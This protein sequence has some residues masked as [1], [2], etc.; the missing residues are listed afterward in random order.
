MRKKDSASDD[1]PLDEIKRQISQ[2]RRHLLDLSKRNRLIN[3]RLSSKSVVE[4]EYPGPASIWETLVVDNKSFTF[5]WKRDL[6]PEESDVDDNG[7]LPLIDEQPEANP[8]SPLIPPQDNRSND[9]DACLASPE[10]GAL[11][12]VTKI[13]DTDLGTRLYRLALNAKTSLSEQGINTLYLAFGFLRYYESTDSD[14]PILAPLLL[15]PVQLSRDSSDA[16]W[17]VSEYE[18]EVVLNHSLGHMLSGSFGLTPPEV[19]DNAL[20]QFQEDPAAREVYFD[21]FHQAIQHQPRWEVLDRVV[22]GIFSFQKLA[23]WKDMGNNSERI[24]SHP[25][26]AAVASG[27]GSEINVNLP[28]L[29]APCDIDDTVPP[30][31]TFHILSADSSQ[32]EAILAAKAGY[33][34]VMDGPPGTG[35]S[36]T[37]AN[38]IA[39]CLAVGKTVL[40]VSEKAAALEVVKRRLDSCNLGDFCLECHSHKANKK[41]VVTELG[42]CLGLT[43]ERYSSQESALNELLDARRKLNAYVQELHRVEEPLGKTP[44]Q[45]HGL[46]ASIKV[47]SV[48]RCPVDNVLE[49]TSERLGTM[50]RAVAR[51]SEFTEALAHFP[52]HPWRQSRVISHSLTLEDDVCYHF[53]L[54]ADELDHAG[55]CFAALHSLGICS[56]LPSRDN[57]EQALSA[58][59]E[60]MAVPDVPAEWFGPG[61]L[62]EVAENSRRECAVRT[63]KGFLTLD[64]LTLAYRNDSSIL[65]RYRPEGLSEQ[66]EAL[67]NEAAILADSSMAY[68]RPQKAD[69]VRSAVV[70]LRETIR[71]C[72]EL[73]ADLQSLKATVESVVRLL[74]V[75]LKTKVTFRQIPKIAR[76]AKTISRLGVVRG[77]WFDATIRHQLK[78]FLSDCISEQ[79][80]IDELHEQLATRLGARALDDRSA[81]LAE[82]SL[83]YRSLFGR[84]FKGWRAFRQE[85]VDLYVAQLPETPRAILADLSVLRQFHRRRNGL[86]TMALQRKDDIPCQPNGDADWK[87]LLEGVE[88]VEELGKIIQ[89]PESLRTALALPGTF[90]CESLA[91]GA[92]RLEQL[93]GA[94]DHK[95]QDLEQCY[96]MCGILGITDES[97]SRSSLLPDE[98]IRVTSAILQRLRSC[99]A[100]LQKIL[101]CLTSDSDVPLSELRDDLSR[102]LSLHLLEQK[103][104]AVRTSL[105][106]RDSLDTVQQRNWHNTAVQAD[107]LLE[108]LQSYA[109]EPPAYC[110]RAAAD[111]SF[112]QQLAATGKMAAESLTQSLKA[113]GKF[114]SQLFDESSEVMPGL[115]MLSSPAAEVASWLRQ[116]VAD[117]YLLHEW[118]R[119]HDLL[120]HLR[121]LGIVTVA[122]EIIQGGL[123]TSD[124]QDAFLARFYRLWLDAVYRKRPSLRGFSAQ[125]HETLIARFRELDRT[126]VA[127]NYK[128]IREERLNAPCRAGAFDGPAMG[129]LGVLRREANK[130]RRHLPLR[131]LFQ[132]IPHW[133]LRL[134]P[135][136]M[137]SPLS[138][139]TYLDSNEIKFDIV[140]FDE[141]SQVRPYD[142]VCAIYRGN[143]LIVA[144]DQKQLPPTTFFDRL[145]GDEGTVGLA[146]DEDYEENI[147]DFESI[148]DVCS[149]LQ[150]PHKRLKWHFRSRRESLIAF[151]NRHFYGNELVT[152]PSVLD[153][154]ATSAVSLEY[155]ADGLW[156]VGSSGGFNR[157]EARQVAQLVFQH[158]RR[159]PRESLGVITMSLRQQWAVLEEIE[160][161][162][163]DWP[164]FELFFQEDKIEPFFVKNLETV[165]GD[166]RDRII[167]SIG[168]GHDESGKFAMRFGPLNRL[169]GERRLN[170]AITRSRF[171]VT[172]VTSIKAQD[173]DLT[174]ANS[175]GSRLL[176]SYLDYAERGVESLKAEVTEAG[177]HPYES[178][179]EMEVA[180]ALEAR[181]MTVHRQIG[182][183]GFRLDLGIVHPLRPGQY[184]LGVECDGASYHSSATA[185]DRDRLRQEILEGLGWKICRVWSTDWVRHPDK[186]IAR[187][188]EAFARAVEEADNPRLIPEI[189]AEHCDDDE[190]PKT[191]PR[192]NNTTT[193]FDSI[194]EVPPEEIERVI[195]ELLTTCGTTTRSDLFIGAARKLGFRRL[196]S[197]IRHATKNTITRLL[198][199]DK[200][201][202]TNDDHLQIS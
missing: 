170:V 97:A 128:R 93:L 200:I 139:S 103:I 164:E 17:E 70:S 154:N 181:R 28:A 155:V 60:A 3:C 186:Q 6:L 165:Q 21:E 59:Q 83:T 104:D 26:C 138:I 179:F 175:V 110:I 85:A 153:L 114:L 51:L 94:L 182:C 53:A 45:I 176:R 12:L 81:N 135:C 98:G 172:V 1:E 133:L 195:L 111:S 107:G 68:F 87:A 66:Y 174:R 148:L 29:P 78:Q 168:Y 156:R 2:W 9:F 147:S 189:P 118:L 24:G 32:H 75:P 96:D 202:L 79:D 73:L 22:L 67:I 43:S 113:N 143:Q 13:S 150:M 62:E 194:S 134:K 100:F 91:E 116:R 49:V 144:G 199:T 80:R 14:I 162:R 34:F 48:S 142:A 112:R 25:L 126:C 123:A 44:F 27:P 84:I 122:E 30:H 177:R 52:D 65:N 39:E 15:V 95:F 191:A 132:R 146:E 185:R 19:T 161:L 105:G 74:V 171:A 57:M 36:Q 190:K 16:P 69:T 5:A 99:Q 180:K 121:E 193:A 47:T 160:R 56:S 41:A 131:Q 50:V 88:L 119:L 127:G 167:L 125:Q 54:L 201:K 46:L 37:I 136:M 4:P 31:D 106:L 151:S 192:P 158:F 124:A 183:S 178:P 40:F 38:I 163:R 197:R 42:R 92:D 76:L 120:A 61:L 115:H 64:A 157:P 58:F 149:T 117:V 137:M 86:R 102:L 33:S 141:A 72:D 101:A 23:M 198:R 7:N 152:F 109:G 196:G 187:I 77:S 71:L 89:V 20:Q 108:M 140:I 188:T 11:D 18:D 129:E 35:K 169:G 55:A 159:S 10:L 145:A 130:A 90:N 8:Q 173:I 63:A 184:V 166:E 82:R